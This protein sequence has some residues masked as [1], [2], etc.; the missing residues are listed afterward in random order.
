MTY[1]VQCLYSEKLAVEA[2]DECMGHVAG[3][4]V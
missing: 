2:I 1:G 3:P 4:I